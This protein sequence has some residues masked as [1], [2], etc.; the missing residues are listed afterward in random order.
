MW[1]FSEIQGLEV[2]AAIGTSHL[3]TLLL[4]GAV[5][6]PSHGTRNRSWGTGPHSQPAPPSPFLACLRAASSRPP[7]LPTHLRSCS[8]ST[9]TLETA[10]LI[11][12]QTP[13]VLA[14][15][16]NQVHLPTFQVLQWPAASALTP[17]A[18]L[19]PPPGASAA[20][21]CPRAREHRALPP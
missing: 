11:P 2:M 5:R 1:I 15:T 10:S 3:S 14:L 9:H 4:R 18:A 8:R 17:H 20:A 21:P 13:P 16:D 6:T 19:L 12:A 7:R